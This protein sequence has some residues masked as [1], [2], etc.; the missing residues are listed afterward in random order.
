MLYLVRVS[1][2]VY[3]TYFKNKHTKANQQATSLLNLVF[4]RQV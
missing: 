1:L 4:L 3:G 2:M